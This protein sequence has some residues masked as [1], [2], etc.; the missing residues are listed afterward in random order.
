MEDTSVASAAPLPR[1]CVESGD[2]DLQAREVYLPDIFLLG[3]N[4]MIYGVYQDWVH[5]NPGDHLDEGIAEDSKWQA[6]WRKLFCTSNQRYDAPSGKVGNIF[7]GI[8][9]VELD[10]VRA[11]KWNAERV[12]VFQS[13]I[14]QRAQGINNSTQTRKRILFWIDLWNIGAFEKLV[15]DVYNCAMVSLVKSCGSQTTTE[16]IKRFRILSWREICVNP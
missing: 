5:Q 8:L 16:I 14:L 7:V 11:R 2:V 12:I 4:Y 10:R 3:S 15:K 9:S 1:P 6:R 13:V